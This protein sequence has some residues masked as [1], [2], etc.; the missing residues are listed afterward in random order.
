MPL[1]K[2]S[3]EFTPVELT[4]TKARREFKAA[5]RDCDAAMDALKRIELGKPIKLSE[6]AVD[7]LI[8][9]SWD[10]RFPLDQDDEQ[11]SIWRE[12]AHD[13]ELNRNAKLGLDVLEDMLGTFNAAMAALKAAS[14]LDEPLPLEW[15]N[16]PVIELARNVNR[17]GHTLLRGR[18][19]GT[20]L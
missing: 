13:G 20:S 19:A 18:L 6:I 1:P 14:Y 15:S 3:N 5:I 12:K 17:L 11:V 9:G 16:L 10:L 2:S 4:I 8:C 7:A